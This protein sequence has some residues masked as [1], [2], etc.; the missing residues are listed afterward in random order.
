MR[1]AFPW[2]VWI[3]TCCQSGS[4]HIKT[5][6]FPLS[7]HHS[8]AHFISVP[9]FP[10]S[11]EVKASAW[12]A[13]DPGSIPESGRSPGEGNGNPLQYSCLEIEWTEKPSSYSPR[14]HKESDMTERLHLTSPHLR[15]HSV[16][17]TLHQATNS[18]C[19]CWRLQDTHGK[20]WVSLLWRS[21]LLFPGSWCTQGFV[22]ALQKPV[23]PVLCKFWWL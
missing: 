6:D 20:V 10:G 3:F 7:H 8:E 18:P 5:Q 12:N 14:G 1:T 19:L 2:V 17:P 21:L 16:P 13:G 22:R 9:G 11:S 23:S 4:D 15:S